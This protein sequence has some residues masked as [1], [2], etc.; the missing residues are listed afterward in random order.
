MRIQLEATEMTPKSI[1][2]MSVAIGAIGLALMVM[3]IVTEDE[4]GA[5]PLGLV[6]LGVI[7]YAT[8]WIRGRSRRI[9]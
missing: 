8:G 4:P 1:N 6:L 9:S 7:G 3:M 2:L 5:L